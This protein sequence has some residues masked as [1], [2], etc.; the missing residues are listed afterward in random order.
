[1]VGK[2]NIL[3]GLVTKPAI[4]LSFIMVLALVS[5]TLT[6]RVFASGTPTPAPCSSTQGCFVPTPVPPSQA[7]VTTF[8][9]GQG[10]CSQSSSSFFGFPTWYK[11]L[12]TETIREPNKNDPKIADGPIVVACSPVVDLSKNPALVGKI[13]LA[14][15]EIMLRIAG[16]ISVF[17]IIYGGFKYILSRGDAQK[18]VGARQSIINAVIGLV[19]AAIAV[20]IV[21][22][23]GTTISG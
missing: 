15:V 7:N 20:F 11:Y 5:P 1:M 23:I 21:Q 12:P 10:G 8:N 13:L 2:R 18:A 17:F 6:G 19:I 9:T 3:R 16:L 14:V 22:L 4:G